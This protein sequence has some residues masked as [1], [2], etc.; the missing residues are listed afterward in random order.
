MIENKDFEVLRRD[1]KTLS[2]NEKLKRKQLEKKIDDELK[3]CEKFSN[4]GREPIIPNDDSLHKKV[5]NIYYKFRFLFFL[6]IIILAL[7][8]LILVNRCMKTNA[9]LC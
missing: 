3:K 6:N 9:N 5:Y 8:L 1:K 4:V 7:R 2:E